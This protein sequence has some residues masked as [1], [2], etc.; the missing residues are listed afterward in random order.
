[1]PP[2]LVPTLLVWLCLRVCLGGGVDTL[3][4]DVDVVLSVPAVDV[5]DVLLSAF[6]GP[7][8]SVSTQCNDVGESCT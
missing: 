5:E 4:V 8:L 6:L 1:M 3:L 2:R 7:L